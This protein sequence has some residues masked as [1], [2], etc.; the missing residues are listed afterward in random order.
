MIDW[1]LG[2]SAWT[3]PIEQKKETT[4]SNWILQ[5]IIAQVN[6]QPNFPNCL[7]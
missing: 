2:N 3:I 5:K 6:L 1:K 7:A 4:I